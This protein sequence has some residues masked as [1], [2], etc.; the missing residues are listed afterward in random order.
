MRNGHKKAYLIAGLIVGIAI[1]VWLVLPSGPTQCKTNECFIEIANKCGT[2]SLHISDE[3][4]SSSYY[5]ENCVFNKTIN[6]ID[7]GES[8]EM[9]DLLEGKEL[10]CNYEQGQF[11]E[12]WVNSLVLGFEECEGSLRD[13]LGDL[14]AFA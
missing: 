3:T 12:R 5:T 10:S 4:G 6:N 2:T 14:I 8:Q 7:P 13:V 11:D 9:K 1:I